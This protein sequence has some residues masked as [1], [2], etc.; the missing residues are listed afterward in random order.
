[1]RTFGSCSLFREADGEVLRSTWNGKLELILTRDIMI[2]R[3]NTSDIFILFSL[4]I[5]N[6]G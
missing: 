5:V 2:H 6:G 4:K 3:E 1:M